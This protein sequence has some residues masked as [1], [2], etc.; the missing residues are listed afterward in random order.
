MDP[1][2][3]GA[4][5]AAMAKSGCFQGMGSGSGGA[6]PPLNALSWLSALGGV[7]SGNWE[8]ASGFS[9]WDSWPLGCGI[10]QAL[11]AISPTAVHTQG[12]RGQG[13]GPA[14]FSRGPCPVTGSGL[15]SDLGARD[16]GSKGTLPGTCCVTPR[17]DTLVLGVIVYKED[18][19]M[20]IAANES[21]SG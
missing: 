13:R 15:S 3:K 5:L 11:L 4:G 18:G 17:N 10:S 6:R 14:G 20:N 9:L 8:R 21:S 16:L 7:A 12:R 2:R 1:G 19:L